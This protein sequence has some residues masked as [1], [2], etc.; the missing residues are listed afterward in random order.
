[1]DENRDGFVTFDELHGAEVEA[2]DDE[3]RNE[4]E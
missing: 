2:I 1:M 3:D 4:M